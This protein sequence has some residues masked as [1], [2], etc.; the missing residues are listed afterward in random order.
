M[1]DHKFQ[2][3]HNSDEQSSFTINN[4]LP[5][6]GFRDVALSSLIPQVAAELM[7]MQYND[8]DDD[9]ANDQDPRNFD[10]QTVEEQDNLRL[11][12]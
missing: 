12:R 11:L 4:E 1:N 5:S 7:G 2:N 10:G 8:D 9:D 6:S 3:D